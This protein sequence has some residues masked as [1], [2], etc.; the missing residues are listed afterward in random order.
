M[1]NNLIPLLFGLILIGYVFSEPVASSTSPSM[2]LDQYN[3]IIQTNN[4]PPPDT[5]VSTLEE[6]IINN[7]RP[8]HTNV[9]VMP[10]YSF[11]PILSS[12]S[13]GAD[14]D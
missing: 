9:S 12:N 13:A 14:L 7:M 10:T 2:H 11:Q 6:E 5:E 4:I 1:L 3:K 8:L